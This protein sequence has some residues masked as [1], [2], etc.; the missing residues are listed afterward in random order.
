MPGAAER[1]RRSRRLAAV[2]GV[3]VVALL[4]VLVSPTG[5]QL[6]HRGRPVPTPAATPPTPAA[7]PSSPRATPGATPS[8]RPAGPV[9]VSDCGRHPPAVRP[10]R[11]PIVC[12]AGQPVVVTEVSWGSWG[13]LNALGTALVVTNS[14]DPTCARGQESSY[15]ASVVLDQVS[16]NRGGTQFGR[17]TVVWGA[18]RPARFRRP[19]Q[20]DLPVFRG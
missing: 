20:V 7:A 15:A 14:C 18:N 4:L 6:L 19:L 10:E 3:V 1:A 8:A 16:T 5:R 9:G 17:A 2:V 13:P 11:L 12:G